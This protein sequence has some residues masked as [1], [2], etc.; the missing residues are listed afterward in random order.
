MVT[1][2]LDVGAMGTGSPATMPSITSSSLQCSYI[3]PLAPTIQG[4]TWHSAR[5]TAHPADIFLPSWSLGRPAALEVHVSIPLQGL[6][7][8][9][10]PCHALQVGVQHKLA[11]NLSACH[12]SGIELVPL[13]AETLGGLA[14]EAI[15]PYHCHSITWFSPLVAF[16]L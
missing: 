1:T 9:P 11:S 4:G 12:K 3:A 15:S 16:L 7:I 13:V 5:I 6:T 14:E 10:T 8:A 2:K